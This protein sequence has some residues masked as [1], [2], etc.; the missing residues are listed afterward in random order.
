MG[1]ALS[2]TVPRSIILVATGVHRVCTTHSDAAPL[3]HLTHGAVRVSASLRGF[4]WAVLGSNQ[5]LQA[6]DLEGSPS[7]CSR[8]RA[9]MPGNESAH[10]RIGLRQ[11][12]V[13]GH[14]HPLLAQWAMRRRDVPGITRIHNGTAPP[15]LET[16]YAITA[17]DRLHALSM[18]TIHERGRFTWSADRG[19]VPLRRL[20]VSRCDR[21]DSVVELEPGIRVHLRDVHTLDD[22]GDVTAPALVK[23]RDVVTSPRRSTESRPSCCRCRPAQWSRRCSAAVSSLR[24]LHADEAGDAWGQGCGPSDRVEGLRGRRRGRRAGSAASSSAGKRHSEA[25]QRS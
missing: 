20:D 19:R 11:T 16:A 12:F 8:V 4:R 21:H 9:E 13:G 10:E 6:V 1:V 2:V 15:Q 17:S 7:I 14:P 5:G 18:N 25:S 3:A 22:V 23:V 24:W